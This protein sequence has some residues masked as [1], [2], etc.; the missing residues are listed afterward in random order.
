[1]YVLKRFVQY[2]PVLIGVSLIAFSMIHL[3]SGGPVRTMLGTQATEEQVEQV[4]D[5]LDL[6]EPLHVQYLDWVS[7]VVRGDFGESI[8]SGKP[9]SE[10]ILTRLPKTVWLAIG[11][12]L[13]SVLIGIPAGIVSATRRYSML[14]YA[15]TGLAFTGI[16][17]PN[18]FL[19][20]LLILMFGG[21]LNLLPVSGFVDP[22]KHPIEGVKHLIL[23]WM[24]LGTALAS[25]VM[26]MMRSS[27]LEVFNEQYIQVA[28]AKG[29]ARELVTNKHA[30]MNAL[31]PT[32][33]II[34]LNVGYLLGGTIV[35]EQI[36]AI[37][38]LGRLTLSAVLNR[39]FIVLQG[40]LLVTAFI[41]T[42]VNFATDMVYAYLDPRIGYE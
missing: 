24:T 16:S 7:G 5:R 1:M 11:A 35:V 38:G 41:F 9:V 36:F 21:Y 42:T 12:T 3:V 18:F 14:D 33:T 23:P 4:R 28:N 6:N 22:L 31:I 26:R 40:V 30:I 17:I 20:I 2:V 37:S 27:L 32:V 25:I 15:A 10:M 13:I 39:D 19:G 34:G 29:L 8:Q